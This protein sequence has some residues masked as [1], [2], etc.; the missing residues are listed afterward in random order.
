MTPLIT[1]V[2]PI[3]NDLQ[4]GYLEK[5]IKLFK[6]FTDIEVILVDGGSTDGSQ[7]FLEEMD[8]SFV[9]AP[10]TNR[11]QR[12]NIGVAKAKGYTIL[13]NH[14]RSLLNL[15][16][17]NHLIKNRERY[18]WGGFTHRFDKA[19]PLL[20]FTSWYSNE[21]RAK[22]KGIL[23]LD[24]CI[25]FKRCLLKDEP[26]VPEI[27]I[28]EDTELSKKLLEY[29][30]PTILPFASTTSSIRFNQNGIFRQS[31]LNQI[32]KICWALGF[33]HEQMNRIYEKGLELNSKV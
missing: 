18:L 19:Q 8:F 33:S 28:F 30:H 32:L 23:Y 4:N 5:Q 11:A 13:L 3:N 17:L 15:K 7:K 31:L 12:I 21:V 6:Q 25:F 26:L 1:V 10:K 27:E 14:P 9:S 2:I 24:H 22:I 29:S 20:S 16:G